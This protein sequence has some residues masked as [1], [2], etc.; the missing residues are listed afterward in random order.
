M[1]CPHPQQAGPVVHEEISGEARATG[2]GGSLSRLRKSAIHSV[3]V[4]RCICEDRPGNACPQLRT[5]CDFSWNMHPLPPGPFS[6]RQAVPPPPECPWTGRHSWEK[7]NLIKSESRPSVLEIYPHGFILRAQFW[8]RIFRFIPG[9]PR[10]NPPT[11]TENGGVCVGDTHMT[12]GGHT[13]DW[14]ETHT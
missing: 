2:I 1:K 8:R 3:C 11:L 10:G 9:V 4:C 5:K 7:K 13:H 14:W 6:H 12:G